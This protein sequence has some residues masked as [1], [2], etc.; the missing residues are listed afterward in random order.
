MRWHWGVDSKPTLY[1][2]RDI[3]SSGAFKL[4]IEILTIAMLKMI[5]LKVWFEQEDE[6]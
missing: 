3:G 4:P 6:I 2:G 5:A 1:I